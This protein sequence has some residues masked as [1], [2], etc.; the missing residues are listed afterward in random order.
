M[1]S[2]G[3]W[4]M[5]LDDLLDALD[6]LRVVARVLLEALHRAEGEDD[7]G[8][9]G[10][11]DVGAED[12]VLA[13]NLPRAGD[14]GVIHAVMRVGLRLAVELQVLNLLGQLR[15]ESLRRRVEVAL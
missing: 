8:L 4:L 11:K 13:V 12:D 10:F 2:T 6:Q 14:G 7:E 1:S 5:R 15:A 3:Y 9:L